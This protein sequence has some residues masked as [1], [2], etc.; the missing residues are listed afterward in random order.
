MKI[1]RAVHWIGGGVVEG[2]LALADPESIVSTVLH[3][4]HFNEFCRSLFERLCFQEGRKRWEGV[5]G[6]SKLERGEMT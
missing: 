1:I 3:C 5:G 2:V 6:V 4:T